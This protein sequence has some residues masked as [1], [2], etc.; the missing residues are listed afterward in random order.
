MNTNTRTMV[1]FLIMG[2]LAIAFIGPSTPSAKSADYAALE[3]VKGIKTVFD[4]TQG[5]PQVANIVFWAINN[6][7]AD[8]SVRALAQPPRV[9]V[10]FHGPSV[11]MIS[12]DRS[13]FKESDAAALDR[14]AETIRQM[15]A[16]GVTFEVC[17]YALQ[18]MGVDPQTVMPEVDRVPNGFISIAGYQAQGYAVITI[19]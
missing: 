8:A 7:N 6:V 12:T 4:V 1:R 14:F 16:D 10:V 13:G 11:K 3:G 17:D 5:S 18:V 9:A 19:N 2:V 15:K